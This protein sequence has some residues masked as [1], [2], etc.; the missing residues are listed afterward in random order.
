M[1]KTIK[2]Q[3]IFI[4][5]ILAINITISLLSYALQVK[6]VAVIK[7]NKELKEIIEIKDIELKEEQ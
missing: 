5:I 7:E 6:A 2:I 3:R 1:Q 4:A